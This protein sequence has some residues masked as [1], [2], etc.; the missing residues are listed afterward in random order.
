LLAGILLLAPLLWMSDASGQGMNH[1]GT[2]GLR[3]EGERKLFGSLVCMCGDCARLTLDVC[4]C[5]FAENR[6]ND[7]REMVAAGMAVEEVQRGFA[8]RWG[9]AAL[10]VPPNEGANRAMWAIPLIGLIVG[11][12]LVVRMLRSWK[13][14]GDVATAAASKESAGRSDTRDKYDDK[15]D[16]ELRELD[17]E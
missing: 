9:P 8:K 11:A 10:I 13:K 12:F 15:L 17:K 3:D 6:R 7:V 2:V 16:D 1:A 4:A 14:R 5:S